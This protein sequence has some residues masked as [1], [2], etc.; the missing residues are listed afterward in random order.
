M[1]YTNGRSPVKIL[2]VLTIEEINARHGTSFSPLH[3]YEGGEVG[4]IRLVDEAGQ[5]FVLK[6]QP[7]GLA[8]ATTEAL[9]TLGYP[10][11]RYILEGPG[12]H[13][14]EE[15]SGRPAGDWGVAQPAVMT[16]LFE[17]NELQSGATV[18]DDTSWPD[19]LVESVTAG[20]S[21]FCVVETLERHSDGSRELLG[22]CRRA[23]ERHSPALEPSRDIAHMDFTLANVL[24]D[25]DHVTGVIDWGGTR[26]GDR[27]F[28]LATLLYYARGEAPELERYVVARIGH[29]GLAVYLA[30]MAVRQTDW[31]LR[32]HGPAAGEHALRHSLGLAR[33]FPR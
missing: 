11:P 23:V 1:F 6:F 24:V 18:D 2:P 13:V 4:A 15:L 29:E 27:M 20:F 32:H 31:S 10:V 21:E 7:T 19:T 12:Y 25:G 33:L 28:D 14:Q 16:R 9:R 30:H 26:T 3:R 8:P 22:L 5:H 17:L